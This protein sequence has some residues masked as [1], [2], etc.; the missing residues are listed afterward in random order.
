MMQSN[1][2]VC[3]VA[4]FA[5][6][7]TCQMASELDDTSLLNVVEGV[8]C[9]AD[10]Y[11]AWPYAKLLLLRHIFDIEQV[12]KP[13]LQQFSDYVSEDLPSRLLNS[14]QIK[15]HIPFL[16]DCAMIAKPQLHVPF[17]RSLKSHNTWQPQEL[18]NALKSLR[19]KQAS[20]ILMT[21]CCYSHVRHTRDEASCHVP[22][23][24]AHLRM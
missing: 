6:S 8:D 12:L 1:P 14:T 17:Y 10:F 9:R 2:D 13:K 23:T 4:K 11:F 20:R 18:T 19:L 21:F 3:K 5:A 24:T 22:I 15:E 16:I 7:F